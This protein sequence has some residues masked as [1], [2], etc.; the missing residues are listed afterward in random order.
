MLMLMGAGVGRTRQ[1]I[2]RLGLQRR[3]E[4]RKARTQVA[5][6]GTKGVALHFFGGERARKGVGVDGPEAGG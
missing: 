2:Q 5:L 3:W 6:K 1:E 4:G